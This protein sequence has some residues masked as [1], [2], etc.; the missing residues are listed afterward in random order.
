[1][2]PRALVEDA[3]FDWWLPTIDAFILVLCQSIGRFF[4]I[5]WTWA[6]MLS[7]V[8]LWCFDSG[9]PWL[10]WSCLLCCLRAHWS[11][12]RSPASTLPRPGHTL[13]GIRR[14]LS[15]L[16]TAVPFLR[17]PIWNGSIIIQHTIIIHKNTLRTQSGNH[18]HLETCRLNC[19]A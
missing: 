9:G 6:W 1:M 17:M 7:S 2:Q 19:G 13:L 18:T 4:S 10:C 15:S 8:W 16:F 14:K 5:S 3:C 11:A 12:S